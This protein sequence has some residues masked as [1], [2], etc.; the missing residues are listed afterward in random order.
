MISLRLIALYNAIASRK[1]E[2]EAM[3]VEAKPLNTTS[4]VTSCHTE[5]TPNQTHPS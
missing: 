4:S 3:A 5:L 2:L 1:Y